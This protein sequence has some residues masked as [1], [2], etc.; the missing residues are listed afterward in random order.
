MTQ[1]EI[2][3]I[4]MVGEFMGIKNL[5]PYKF[6]KEADFAGVYIGEDEDGYIDWVD[7]GINWYNPHQDWNLLMKVVD[8]IKE[9]KYPIY[10]YQSHIQ[11][12]VEIFQ[13][14]N[15]KSYLIRESSTKLEPIKLLYNA[16]VE[17]VEYYNEIQIDNNK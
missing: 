15:N 5:F 3:K 14:S 11:N 6:K 9:L 12:T 2:D 1:Q 7:I 16:V 8:K 17:F 4:I 13:L 10:I